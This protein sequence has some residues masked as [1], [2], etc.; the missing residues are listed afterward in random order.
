[1]DILNWWKGLENALDAAALRQQVIANNIANAGNP[2][3]TGKAVAFEEEVQKAMAAQENGDLSVRPVSLDES[4]EDL[5][6][7]D[8]RGDAG[9]WRYV[10]PKVYDTGRPIDINQEM[11]NLAK[12]QIQ[13]NMLSNKIGGMMKGFIN[14]IDQ[15]DRR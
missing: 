13:Y 1:M 4:E 7:L 10:R 2:N 6:K 5:S 15:L 12:N 8:I 14:I 9:S 11:V 3:F